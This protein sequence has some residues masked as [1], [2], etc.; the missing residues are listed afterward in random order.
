MNI[1]AVASDIKTFQKVSRQAGGS[2]GAGA[3]SA[4]AAAAATGL[5]IT[6]DTPREERQRQ[7]GLKGPALQAEVRAPPRLAPH[8]LPM[9]SCSRSPSAFAAPLRLLLSRSA[10]QLL[11]LLPLFLSAMFRCCTP[12][13]LPRC[14]LSWSTTCRP[15]ASHTACAPSCWSVLPACRVSG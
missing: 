15:S 4:A 3:A 8:F 5:D 10:Q 7:Y 9:P 1:R 13:R 2:G 14:P 11:W 6:A 12:T